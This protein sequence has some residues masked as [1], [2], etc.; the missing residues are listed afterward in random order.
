MAES[1]HF[2]VL[3]CR[4]PFDVVLAGN[5]R[6]DPHVPRSPLFPVVASVWVT[7]VT[8]LDFAILF[9]SIGIYSPVIFIEQPPKRPDDVGK[10]E[11]LRNIRQGK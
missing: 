4:G 9:P 10:P 11:S 7:R 8:P 5:L 6:G 3:T 1:P 2:L